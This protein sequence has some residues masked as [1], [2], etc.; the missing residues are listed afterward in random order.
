MIYAGR[1]C[2]GLCQDAFQ[3]VCCAVHGRLLRPDLVWR[4]AETSLCCCAG[5]VPAKEARQR[6]KLRTR[7]RRSGCRREDRVA[8]GMRSAGNAC[9]HHEAAIWLASGFPDSVVVA[10]V[11]LVAL[12]WLRTV[13]LSLIA[14]VD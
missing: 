9:L 6:T 3:R 7:T 10:E 2:R 13:K 1:G 5:A 14:G 8:S 4:P 12:P 11:L